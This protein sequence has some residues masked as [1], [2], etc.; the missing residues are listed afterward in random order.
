YVVWRLRRLEWLFFFSSRR[1]HT[2]LVSDWSSDVCSSDLRLALYPLPA[3]VGLFG[4]AG[5]GYRAS[6]AATTCQRPRAWI[7][8][9]AAYSFLEIGRASCR[10]REESSA[11]GVVVKRKMRVLYEARDRC[12][13]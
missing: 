7:W 11:E 1:R 9:V 12:V 10:E 13:R 5:R 6:L 8:A 2:R 3:T 4:V